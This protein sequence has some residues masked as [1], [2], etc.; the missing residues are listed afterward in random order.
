MTPSKKHQQAA[1]IVLPRRPD[2]AEAML[3]EIL[4][5]NNPSEERSASMRGAMALCKL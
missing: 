3:L 2:D 4:A 5:Q 1:T